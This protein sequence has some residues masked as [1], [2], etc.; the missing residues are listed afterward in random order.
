LSIFESSADSPALPAAPA[1]WW[2][3]G[4]S[5]R[6]QSVTSD[7]AAANR[8]SIDGVAVKEIRPVLKPDGVLTEVFR[9]DWQLDARDLAHV[10]SLVM[11]PRALS[12][13]HVHAAT[14]DR[15]FV[16]S[17]QVTLVLFD[18][19]RDSATFQRVDEYVIGERRPC[20]VSIPPGV[21]HGVQNRSHRPAVLLNAA[22][23]AYDYEDPDHW[24]LPADSPEIPYRFIP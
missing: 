22:D 16:V 12:A 21:W 4:A 1:A 3:P 14:T 5:R 7:W 8:S 18:A 15:L 6:R 11:E 17:G 9:R 13:W 23:R 10:F 24:S 19:R 20:T 2:L